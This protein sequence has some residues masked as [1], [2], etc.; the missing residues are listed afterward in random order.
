MISEQ[1]A[2]LSIHQGSEKPRHERVGIPIKTKPTNSTNIV[3]CSFT[4]QADYIKVWALL[5]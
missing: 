1:F 5:A 3:V 2:Q 4:V